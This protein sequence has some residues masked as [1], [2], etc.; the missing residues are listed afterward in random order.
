ML[1]RF[2]S[3][4]PLLQE[5]VNCIMI[6]HATVDTSAGPVICPYPPAPQ[7][8]LFF[9]LDDCIS[10]K[11]QGTD[12]FIDQPRS[13]LVG[14]QLKGV[15]INI[16]RSHKA[17]RIGF[18]P[19][20]MFRLLG[21][22]MSEFVDSS[23][24]AEDVMGRELRELNEQLANCFT[25]DEI[26]AVVES[27]LL[28]KLVHAKKCLPIDFVMTELVKLGGNLSV[29]DAAALA[30][31][32]VRQFERLSRQRVGMSPKLYSRLI[33]FSKA[34]RLRENFS[35]ASWTDIAYQCG[36][37]DQ[38]HFIRDFKFFAGVIP[39]LMDRALENIPVKLQATMRL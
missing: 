24:D 18:Q 29:E 11:K 33:R 21:I 28:R 16:N 3:P 22:P 25:F 38:M 15:S 12:S 2:Y 30:C 6:V 35:K 34:Y 7:D 17:V 26:H 4:H 14:T 20:G 36:Y 27:F 23:Y 13:V 10:V 9:Y 31:I 19:G 1:T 39:T 32:S 5:F 8:S 37:F